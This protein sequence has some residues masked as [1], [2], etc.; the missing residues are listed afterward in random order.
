MSERSP[1]GTCDIVQSDGARF[2][3]VGR[4]VPDRGN[5]MSD[6]VFVRCGAK[7]SL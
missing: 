1:D 3:R 5:R 7:G 6:V 4:V 2:R